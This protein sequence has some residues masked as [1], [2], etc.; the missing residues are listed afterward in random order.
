MLRAERLGDRREGRGIERRGVFSFFFL[1]FNASKNCNCPLPCFFHRLH[2]CLISRRASER[3]RERK[4]GDKKEK[5]KLGRSRF[6]VVFSFFPFFVLL[7]FL[8]SLFFIPTRGNPASS[9]RRWRA[10]RGCHFRCQ[11]HRSRR[12]GRYR[13]QSLPF[14]LLHQLL[15]LLLLRRRRCRRR[16]PPLA[17][18]QGRQGRAGAC[19]R[20]APRS[21]PRRERR[22]AREQSAGQCLHPK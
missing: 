17:A 9:P 2:C 3:E 15:L 16:L 11:C 22:R 12:K 1:F 7:F 20:R 21:F 14:R 8:L 10:L 6:F 13:D 5:K 4:E 18:P 19:P